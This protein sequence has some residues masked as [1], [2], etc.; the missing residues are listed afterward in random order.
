MKIKITYFILLSILIISVAVLIVEDIKENRIYDIT[1]IPEECEGWFSV[2]PQG[3]FDKYLGSYDVIGDLRENSYI[4]KDGNLVVGFDSSQVEMIEEYY[5]SGIETM[6]DLGIIVSDD[7][8]SIT[9]KGYREDVDKMLS[10]MPPF[11]S[12]L[13]L[14]LAQL[15][16]GIAPHELKLT[17]SFVDEKTGNAVYE[18]TF[19]THWQ[20]HYKYKSKLTSRSEEP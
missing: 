17:I 2:T 19:N 7:Y 9:F 8:A 4:D 20:L 14:R 10:D 3:F 15:M 12:F 11:S 1:F 6:K 5:M 16:N 18:E 13:S